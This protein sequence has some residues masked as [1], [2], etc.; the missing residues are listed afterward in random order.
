MLYP[1]ANII[2]TEQNITVYKLRRCVAE[3]YSRKIYCI[4]LER[5]Y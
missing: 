5:K 1:E 3:A 4:M 2:T